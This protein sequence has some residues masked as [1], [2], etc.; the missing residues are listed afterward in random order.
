MYQVFFNE[1]SALVFKGFSQQRQLEIINALNTITPD[2]LARPEEPFGCFK[3]ADTI[4][5]RYRF[6][7]LRFY[8]TL[9]G[10]LIHCVYIL[11]KNTWGDF[12]LRSNLEKVSDIEVESKPHFWE[13][14]ENN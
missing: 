6:E 7:D 1:K 3:R 14:L 8:F 11:Q 10:D 5:Y 2:S 9:K 4:Y 13:F 12:C